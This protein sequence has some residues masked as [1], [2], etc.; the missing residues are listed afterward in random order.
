[1]C[2]A[3]IL[4]GAGGVVERTR[5]DCDHRVVPGPTPSPTWSWTVVLPVQR[6]EHGKSRLRAPRHVERS[7][8]ARAIAVDSITGVLDSP[9]VGAVVLVTSDPVV[10]AAGRDQARAGPSV[11]VLDDPG[12]GLTAAV[13]AGVQLARRQ[14]PGGAVAA[15]LAD[16]PA[17][18][19]EDLTA[20][21][22]TAQ[23]HSRA[24]VPDHEGAGTV[25]LT[26][27]PGV[28]LRH[29]FGPGSA[30]RH[31]DL[32][33]VV[34]EL[35]LPRLRRDVDTAADLADAVRLGVGA[36]TTALLEAATAVRGGS[37]H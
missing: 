11:Q 1:V 19:G 36:S 34:L 32:G 25:L 6:A 27:A 2:R 13:E 20:A 8:L 30:A 33:A 14:R 3:R 7:A 12:R 16:V 5:G 15:L 23:A 18:R 28:S 35:D 10:A 29:A 24:V 37:G 17:L 21:L 9:L 31:R 26:A 22:T 4:A